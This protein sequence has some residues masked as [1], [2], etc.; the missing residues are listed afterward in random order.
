MGQ[1]RDVLEKTRLIDLGYEGCLFTWSNK[2]M[3]YSFT[4]ERLDRFVGNQEWREMFPKV[5]VTGLV[6]ITSYHRPIVVTV[7][8]E[9]TG[10]GR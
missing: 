7:I 9:Y 1:S 4:K 8:E 3:D 6:V 5:K 2:H 10:S